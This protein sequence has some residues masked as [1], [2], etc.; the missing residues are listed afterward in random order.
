MSSHKTE[1]ERSALQGGVL[2]IAKCVTP[3]ISGSD[4]GELGQV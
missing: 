3:F 1:T 2:W 4:C